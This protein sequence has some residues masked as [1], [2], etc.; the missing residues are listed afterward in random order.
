MARFCD[1]IFGG[2]LVALIVLNSEAISAQQTETKLNEHLAQFEPLVGK[3][4][5]GE[6]ANSTK[7]KPVIDIAQWEAALNGNAIRVLH[8]V[9]DGVYGGES[10]LMWD[11]KQQ[12]IA[13]WYFTTA[14]FFTQATF[15]ADGNKWTAIEEVTGNANGITKVKSV[16]QLEDNGDM[17]VKSEYFANGEWTPGH[18]IRYQLAPDAKVKFK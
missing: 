1:L 18:E 11:P 4:W 5:K 14:G 7:E 17:H 8:S 9:N 6:F 15:E 16:T 10:I 2:L 13:S 3:T 12:K